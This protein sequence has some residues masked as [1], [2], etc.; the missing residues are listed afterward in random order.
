MPRTL[1][2]GADK[3]EKDSKIRAKELIWC[4]LPDSIRHGHRPRDFKS[5]HAPGIPAFL[6][7]HRVAVLRSGTHPSHLVLPWKFVG[8][9]AKSCV[10]DKPNIGAGVMEW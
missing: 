4:P 2:P 8:R 7:S 6:P 5:V 3:A 10:T 9:V 1:E